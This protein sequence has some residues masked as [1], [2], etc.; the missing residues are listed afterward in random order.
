MEELLYINNP[1]TLH[2]ELK[3]FHILRKTN[4]VKQTRKYKLSQDDRNLILAKTDGRCHICGISL[5]KEKFEA[6]HVKSHSKDGQA[7]FE[8]FLPACKTCN[9]YRWDYLPIEIKWI[10]KIG[11]WART[12]IEKSS[13]IGFEIAQKFTSHEELRENRR[14]KPRTPNNFR[15]VDK[16]I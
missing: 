10:L 14:N 2:E 16:L 6:D 13:K 4:K 11:V 12:E 9:N 8:N 3:K 7:T 1:Q 5:I 15:P